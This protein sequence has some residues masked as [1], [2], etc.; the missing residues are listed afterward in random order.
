VTFGGG[1]YGLIALLTFIIIELTQVVKFFFSITGWQDIISFL[2]LDTLIAMIIDSI[3][4]M[5]QAAIWFR[6]W[7]D[8][9]NTENFIV[10]ILI[11]YIGYR[12]AA[13]Y[14]M[15]YTIYLQKKADNDT[16]DEQST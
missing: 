3:T 11:A 5:I 7:S 13:K 10:W 2:S 4:N 15:R 9:F 1:F 8:K 16:I 12:F 6:Y 14:A